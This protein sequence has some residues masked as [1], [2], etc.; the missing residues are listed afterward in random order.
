M[1]GRLLVGVTLFVLVAAVA[2]F[3]STLW[4]TGQRAAGPNRSGVVMLDVSGMRA[5]QVK[6]IV[7][8]IPAVH[9]TRYPVFVVAEKH[10]RFGAFLG[11]SPHLGCRVSW[12]GD[13]IYP[14]FSDVQQDAFEDPCSGAMF[15]I[16]GGCFAGPCARG[17]DR[18]HTTLANGTL[19]IDLNTL[20]AGAPK[21]T[22][23]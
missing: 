9:G 22:A 17:L 21:P 3:G 12:V 20:I 6:T 10:E 5:G 14:R 13:P 4:R 7:R 16:D 18:L 19:R 1:R 8:P 15:T 2:V 11:R 23:V